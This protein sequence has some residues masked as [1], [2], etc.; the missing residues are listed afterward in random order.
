MECRLEAHRIVSISLGKMY[1]ARGQRGGAKLH[2]NLLVSL[3]LR[4]ARQAFLG[5]AGAG[6]APFLAPGCP[7]CCSPLPAPP[8]CPRKR[9]AAREDEEA[10]EGEAPSKKPRCEEGDEGG[11]ESGNV[12]SLISIF[13]SSFSGLLS[14]KAL[15]CG[16]GGGGR[17]RQEEEEALRNLSP[18]STA[19]VAF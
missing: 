16:E 9:S 2:K 12:A 3:V 13:G 7:C 6:M 10:E 1:S 4:S 5:G 18:W 17:R 19:I 14:K 8:F 11:V 15:P